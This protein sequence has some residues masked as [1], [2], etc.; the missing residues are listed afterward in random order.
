MDRELIMLGRLDIKG[1]DIIRRVYS[2]EGISPTL[3]T[4]GGDIGR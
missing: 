1:Q 3:T 4:C 2:P